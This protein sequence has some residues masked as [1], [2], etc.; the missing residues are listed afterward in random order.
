VEIV[1]EEDQKKI[2]PYLNMECKPLCP[3]WIE[4]LDDCLF[5]V[6][7]TEVKEVFQTAAI[8]LDEALGLAPGIGNVTLQNLRA[9]LRGESENP[10]RDIRNA[11][12]LVIG[13]IAEKMRSAPPEVVT[14][15]ITK[16]IDSISFDLSD[17]FGDDE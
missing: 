17:I 13:G 5:H 11:I 14:Q 1:V 3:G 6:C 8:Y 12:S 9:A 15:T 16:A 7:L 4:P 10:D 2:C